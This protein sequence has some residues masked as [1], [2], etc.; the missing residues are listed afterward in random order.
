MIENRLTKSSSSRKLFDSIKEEYNEA[1][2]L[3][4]YSYDINYTKITNETTV[5]KRKGK[6]IWFNPPY[7][8]SVSK[9]KCGKQ[10]LKNN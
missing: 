1:L 2:K 9:N 10:I 4:G 7:Y 8:C 6:Y 5:K 3:N